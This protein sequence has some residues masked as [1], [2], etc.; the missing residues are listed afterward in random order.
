MIWPSQ[1]EPGKMTKQL[2]L[3]LMICLFISVGAAGAATV[4]VT[5]DPLVIGGGARPLGMGRAFAAL[6]SD[7]DAVFVN[8][9]GAASL[10]EPQAMAM[11]T[12]LLGGTV[13]YSEYCGALPSDFGSISIGFID[14]GTSIASGDVNID[15]YD[16]LLAFN[17]A[18]AL[19]RFFQY[20]DNVLCGISLKIFNRGFTGGLNQSSS[21]FS[22]DFGVKYVASP[23]LNFALVRQNFLPVS[24]GAGLRSSGGAY[25]ALAGMTKL[26]VA[27]KPV[28]FDG[29]LALAGELDIPSLSSDPTTV[30]FG[31]EWK[32]APNFYLRCGLDES[33]D[34]SAPGGASWNPTLG[35]SFIY[36]GFRMDYAYHP[37][38]NDPALAVSYVSFSY[39]GEPW[40]ALKGRTD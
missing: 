16:S 32:T 40:L 39:T 29:A 38:Y 18:S 6:A 5:D 35:T 37:Y 17:Y 12:N 22:S 19:S 20:G 14:T 1:S 21:G 11:F 24:L 30:H 33:V 36:A 26:A 3:A 25:E 9:A 34:S 8:P 4:G 31:T 28:P 15:Y 2:Y 23:Y 10:K 27:V 13:Y 7:S